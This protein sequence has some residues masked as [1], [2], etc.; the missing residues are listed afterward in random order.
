MQ[1][2]VNSSDLDVHNILLGDNGHVLLCYRALWNEVD[3]QPS[4]SEFSAPEVTGNLGKSLWKTHPSAD[5]WSLGAILH[6]LLTG[7]V[8]KRF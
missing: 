5:W 3:I 7:L 2:I 6:F 8:C 1:T 4:W